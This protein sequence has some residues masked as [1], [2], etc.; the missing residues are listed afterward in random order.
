MT[1]NH[2]GTMTVRTTLSVSVPVAY[3]FPTRI[4]Q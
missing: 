2:P 4:V 3:A 1:D